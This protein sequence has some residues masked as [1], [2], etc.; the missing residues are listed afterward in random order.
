M[1]AHA[2]RSAPA[3]SSARATCPAPWPYAFALTTAMT[4]GAR[5]ASAR[6]ILDDMAIVRFERAQIHPRH[7]RANHSRSYLSADAY[8]HR[9]ASRGSTPAA[10][11]VG[12]QHAMSVTPVNSRPAAPSVT[13][14]AGL[15]FEQ[16]RLQH[17]RHHQRA[18]DADDDAAGD[19][20]H[21][22]AEHQLADVAAMGADRR[23]DRDLPPP[24]GDRQRQ[25]AVDADERQQ[26]ATEENPTSSCCAK[27]RDASESVR[28]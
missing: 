2:S 3:S 7:G 4:P 5:A 16:Q 27:M 1:S 15:H 22:F 18:R 11:R 6:E 14:S 21:S 26:R 19:E 13:G 10:R 25:N 28:I 17:A 9:S 23:A 8:S 20:A 12:A 24:R